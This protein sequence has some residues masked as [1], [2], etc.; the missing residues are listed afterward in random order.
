MFCLAL[1]HVQPELHTLSG[2]PVE[3]LQLLYAWGNS[4]VILFASQRFTASR[5]AAHICRCGI[6]AGV[7][8]HAMH[9]HHVQETL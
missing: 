8:L 4:L 9:E 6:H 1:T 5:E 3:V 2:T 7:V